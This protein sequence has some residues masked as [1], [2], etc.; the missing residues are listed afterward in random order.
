M[1]SRILIGL[2][3]AGYGPNIGPLVIGAS[4]WEVPVQYDARQL[5]FDLSPAFTDR[6]WSAG[7]AHIPLGDSKKLY[8]SGNGLLTLETG[9]HSMLAVTGC[10]S[11]SLCE[12]IENVCQ[13]KSIEGMDRLP[14]YSLADQPVMLEQTQEQITMMCVSGLQRL[15]QAG[16]KLLGM[17]AKIISEAEFNRTVRLLGSKGQLLSIQTIQLAANRLAQAERPIEVFCDRHGG[18]KKYLPLLVELLAPDWFEILVES[19]TV[20]SYRS[21]TSPPRTFHFTVG[22][23]DFPPVGLASMIAKYLRERLM[24][25]INNYWRQQIPGLRATAGYPQDAKRFR[26]EIEERASALGFDPSDWWRVC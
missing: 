22:G 10:H 9:V 1:S 25:L 16:I 24:R 19:P 4:V 6:A 13:N 15:S 18:R 12:L 17:Q 20:S 26:S 23:D 3:E 8:S 2:D 14:W 11:R 7:D 21:L 5:K